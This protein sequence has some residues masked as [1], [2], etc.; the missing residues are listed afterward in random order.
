MTKN[1]NESRLGLLNKLLKFEGKLDV[2]RENLSAFEWDSEELI[3][4]KNDHILHVLDLLV[5]QDITT[6]DVELWANLIEGREDIEFSSEP[7]QDAIDQLAN[8]DLYGPLDKDN[9]KALR[10]SLIEN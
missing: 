10:K 9:E 1:L 4:V 8:P 5:R 7:V 6:K 2:I 3:C